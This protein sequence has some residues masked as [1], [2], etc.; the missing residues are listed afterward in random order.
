MHQRLGPIRVASIGKQAVNEASPTLPDVTGSEIV[1][2]RVLNAPRQLVFK[3]WTDPKQVEKWW[4]PKG[5]KSTDC[6]ADL[7]VGGLFRLQMRGPDGAI[8]PCRGIIREIVEPERIVYLGVADEGRACG[9]GLPPNATVT[10][11][12]VEHGGRTTLTIH[13]RLSSAAQRDGHGE[14]RF[15]CRLD[16]KPRTPRGVSRMTSVP[17]SADREIVTT[18]VF[19]A[20]RALV[21]QAWTRPEHIAKWWGPRGFT[22]TI[23]EMDVRPGGRWR[24]VMHGPDGV[25]YQNE[26]VFVEVVEPER[27]VYDHFSGP[28]FHMT[29]LFEEQHGKTRIT[30]RMLFDTAALRDKVAKDFGAVKGAKQTLERLAAFLGRG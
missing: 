2:T 23:Y 27:I 29:V 9:A 3:A 4:G 22:N 19:D 16:L 12:F 25:D 28:K 17:G 13:T 30:M 20:P 21:F 15:R 1:I 6:E 8:Y 5:F 11:T 7:R 14:G 18:R 24:F 10:I 26:I